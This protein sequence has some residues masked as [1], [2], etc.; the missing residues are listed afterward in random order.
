MI[1]LTVKSNHNPL[2]KTFDQKIVTIGSGNQADLNLSDQELEPIHIQIMVEGSRILA[3]NFANDPFVTLNDLPFG[4]KELK[5]LDLL[6]LGS[7][8]I[9]FEVENRS[10]PVEK[11]KTLSIEPVV[12]T[13]VTSLEKLIDNQ[14]LPAPSNSFGSNSSSIPVAPFFQSMEKNPTDIAS[15]E[16]PQKKIKENQ[17]KG[18]DLD[19]LLLE[20]EQFAQ[21]V[22]Q[23]PEEKYP[24]ENENQE[25]QKIKFQQYFTPLS[26][27]KEE[28]APSNISS[29]NKEENISNSVPASTYKKP[30][31][32]YQ[33]G[34]FD[35]ESENWSTEKEGKATSEI[36]Q[37]EPSHHINWK[38]VGIITLST[39]LVLLL[40]ATALYFN[41]TAKNEDEELR[42]AESV[43]DVA[44]ALK[45]AQIHHIKPNKKNWSDPEFIKKSLAQVIP[46]DYPSLVK[47]D[48][49][50]HLNGTSYS[51][52]IYTSSDF[53]RFLVI[54]QPAPRVLQWLIPKT[55]I[56]IDSKHMQLK[57]VADMKALNRLLVNSNNL[58]NSN[59]IEVTQLVKRGELISL[60]RLANRH[61][62]QDF[63]PPKALALVRPGAENYV[64]NA[65]RYYQ[66][67]ETIMKR[68]IELMETPGSA[69]EMS[70]L[71]Q[72]MS[73]LSKMNDMVLYSSDGIQ[74]TL[75]AQK[76]LAVFV[77]NARFLTAYLK[78]DL[79][80]LIMNTH[81]II[82]DESSHYPSA[83]SSKNPIAKENVIAEPIA[84]V[85][86]K[87]IELEPV[88]EDN[89]L[90]SSLI[91]L[92]KN[93][94]NA[95]VPLKN[96]ILNLLNEDV[97]HPMDRFETLLSDRIHEYLE[98]DGKQKE[99]MAKAL[100][101]IAEEYRLLPIDEFMGNLNKAGLGE[102]C[103]EILKYAVQDFDHNKQLQIEIDAIRKAESFTQ[104][105]KILHNT[106][107]WLIIKNFS[108]LNQLRW[109]Q[110]DI[111]IEI[112]SRI[113]QLLLSSMP[114][115]LALRYDAKQR[116]ALQHVLQFTL[117]T[118]EE[119]S[120][121][122]DE[123]ER[124]LKGEE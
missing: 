24:Q 4:K 6:Q 72:D 52:R 54:A 74:L 9:L 2:I 64:Y 63:S 113:N 32:E 76:A 111:K 47:I 88:I 33:V 94:E 117:N 73:L 65:P 17:L 3:I 58:D 27:R 40:I 50:G 11:R 89:P 10:Q 43:A 82:D 105:E 34:E 104:L 16:E 87:T 108:D 31:P 78:F 98:V 56:V 95:L 35:D 123:Y 107:Q 100:H 96:Q 115:P 41:V 38:L 48:P 36:E 86:S 75:D 13:L 37:E 93:R 62:G 109:T 97:N 106:N 124:W 120:Y 110:R 22:Q 118:P 42:A 101:Q 20:V 69:Y 114:P 80:G 46:H 18:L 23:N 29:D 77:S 70:R 91:S 28:I 53:S 67:G 61:K 66:L 57:K 84:E 7:H 59:A 8:S 19:D 102:G 79:E 116:A 85:V 119:Q 25:D 51:L 15:F 21:N 121:Y 99:Q 83:K 1:R 112:I 5:N 92:C 44:M 103:K 71:K 122:L 14:V 49:Q 26:P 12:D 39:F 81:L 55:A 60:N 45:Y 90:L 68:A 30:H